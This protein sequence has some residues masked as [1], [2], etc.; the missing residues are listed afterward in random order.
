VCYC[1]RYSRLLYLMHFHSTRYCRTSYSRR[2]PSPCRVPRCQVEQFRVRTESYGPPVYFNRQDVKAAIH[3][4]LNVEW[5]ECS[6][7]DVFPSGDASLP[8]VFTVLPNVIEKS[9]RSVIAHGLLDFLFIAEGTRIVFQKWV[10][11]SHCPCHCLR[12]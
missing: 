2:K 10:F 4:P 6:N 7:S 11:L 5:S 12:R 9:K 8:S 3:A 1:D